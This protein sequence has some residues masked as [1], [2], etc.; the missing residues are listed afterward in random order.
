[1]TRIEAMTQA[2]IAAIYFTETGDDGQPAADAELSVLSKLQANQACR[3]FLQAI[4]S[5]PD[6]QDHLL[7]VTQMGHDLWFTRNGHGV[8]FWD[9][10]A[11]TYGTDLAGGE[12]SDWFTALAHA[13][14][15]HEVEFLEEEHEEAAA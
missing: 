13:M 6:V 8:G 7:D 9:R 5:H 11:D 2:Y 4:Q 1:M 14:G 3:N 10:P 15:A 12:L